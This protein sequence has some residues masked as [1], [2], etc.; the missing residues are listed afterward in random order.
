MSTSKAA[1]VESINKTHLRGLPSRVRP[2]N[3]VQRLK[4]IR[5]I[6]SALVEE[7]ASLQHENR[8]AEAAA[9]VGTVNLESGIDFFEVVRSFEIRLIERAM[10]LADGNQ[11]RAAKMLGLNTTT[12]NYK[13]KTYQLL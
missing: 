9:T 10:E 4:R 2:S 6:A 8:M 1:V 3:P 11:A 7:T 12:L 13:I 5:D